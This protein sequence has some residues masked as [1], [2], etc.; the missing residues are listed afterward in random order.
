MATKLQLITELSERTARTITKNPV[1]WTSFLKTASW[2]YKYPFQDQ[3]LIYAQRPDATACAPIELWNRKLDRWVNRGAKGIALIDDSGSRLSLRHVFDVSDTNSRYDRPI[4]L[5]AMQDRY[6]E[7]VTETLENAFGEPEE[8]QDMASALISAARNAVED[9]FPDYLTDLVDCRTNSF[10]EELDNLNVEVIFKEVLKNSIAYMLLVRCGYNADEYLSLD[11]LQGVFNFN[12]LDTVSRLGAATSDISEMVLREIGATVKEMQ[13]TE[14]KKSHTFAKNQE[15]RHNKNVKQN[16]DSERNGEYGTDLHAQGRLSDSRPDVAGGRN[17]H[18]QIWDVAQNISEKP[19]ERDVRQP[20]A[21]GQANGTPHGDRPDGEGTRRENHGEALG[22]QSRTGQGSR[23]D[24]LDGTHEQ[25]E[26]SSGGNGAGG[27]DL[28][29]NLFPTFE[30][31]IEVIE[32]AEEETSSAFSIPQEV[33]DSVLRQGSGVQNGKYRIYLHF[34]QNASAKENADFL[35]NEYGIGGHGPA[36]IDSKIDEWHD[37]KGITLTRGKPI[38]PDSKVV[39][40]WAKVQKRIGELIAADRYL[41]IKEKECL[42]VYERQTEERGQQFA[43]EDYAREILN[44]EP[45]PSE[46]KPPLGED[47]RYNFSLGDTV[48]LGTDEY[49]IFSYDDSFVQ[50]RDINFPLLGKELSRSDFDRMLQEN[51]LNDHLISDEQETLATQAEAP[52][53]Q[54]AEKE[55]APSPRELYQTYLPQIINR[56]RTDE[57]YPY[58]WDKDTDPDSAERE[59]DNA[60]HRIMLSMREEHSAFYQAYTSLPKFKEWLHEDVFQWIYQDYLTEKRDSAT[61]HADDPDAPEWVRATGDV[62]ITPEGDTVTIDSEDKGEKSYVEFDLEPPDSQ[63]EETEKQPVEITEKQGI[64]KQPRVNFHI[65]DDDLG[66]GGAK[67]KYG[68]NVDAI[69]LLNQLEEQNRLATPEEQEILS[70]YVGWG[71]LPQV[72]DEQNSQWA[73]EYTELKEL[74]TDEEY[75]SARASTLN[76]HYTSPIVIKA[77]YDCLANMGFETGNILE[78][79]CGTGNFFGLVPESMKNSK[80]YGVELDG[81]TGRIAKQLYQ[82]ASIAVQGFEETNLPDS[83]FDLAVGNVPFGSYGVADKKYDKYKFYIH[84]YFFAKTLDKVR[85]GGII[86]FITSKGTLDKQNPEV[87]KYIAQRAELLGAVRLPNNAFLANAGTEVTTDI[88]F[89]QKRDRV[90]DI[91]PD[92]VHLSTIGDGISINQYF[93]DNP[94]M[95]LGTMAYDERMYG[96][97]NETTCVPHEDTDLSELLREALENIHAEITEY[98]LDEL[99][100]D[101]D[102]SIPADSDVRNFSFCLMDGE[103]YYRENSRMNRVETSVTAQ[104]R[105]KGMIAIRD[106]VRELIEYQTEDYSDEIIREQQQKLN[107]LYDA[108]TAKYGLLNSRG[109]NMAFSDDS[110]YCLLC[111]LEILD[112]DGNLERKADMFTKRTIRQRTSVTHVDTATEALAISIGEKACVDIGFMQT[113]TGLSE[114]QILKELEGV[115]FRNPEKTDNEGNPR[116]ETEDEYLSGNVR[117]KLKTARQF[118]EMYPDLYGV[119]VKALEAVQPKDL[120]ASQIDVRLGATWLPPDVIKDFMLELLETPYMY[121]RYIGVL[122]SAYTA[123]WNVKGKNDDR[124]DNIKANVTYGTKRINAYKIIEETLNLKDVRIFDTIIEDGNEKRVLNKKETAIAQQKQEAIKEAFQSWIWKDPQRRERLTRIYNDR[125]NSIRPREYDGSHIRFTGMNPEITLRKHQVD[126][127]AH[128][129]YGGNTLLAHCVGAGKTYEMAAI[130]MESKHLGLCQKSLFVVPNHLTEQWAAE[131]LQ[132]YPSANILVST[133]K[134][135]ETKN[136]KKFCARIATGD[137]DAVI[138]GHSQFEKIPISQE[139]QKRQLEEQISEI[140]GGIRELKEEHGE[141][142]AIKQLEKT[143]KTLKLRLDKLNDTSRKDDVVTFEEL[144]VDRLF[145]DEADFY[146]N[147]FLYTKMRN[148]AGLSQTNA[149][150]SSDLFAKC[151]YLDERTEGRGTIFATGTPISN[152]ITEMYTMQRYLQYEVL[153]RNGLQ[154]FDCWASTFGETVTAIE[155]A[156]EGTG[157]RAKTRF[158][159]FYNLPELMNMFKEVADIKTADML[160]LPVP[161]ANYHNVAV[162]PSEFQQNMVAELAERA[163]RVRN[164]MVEPYEDNMLKITNDGRKLALDQR[165][166]NPMLPDHDRSKVNACVDNTFQL[167][168]ENRDQRLTQLVFCDLSTP[169]NDGNFNIY[170]DVRQKLIDRGVPADEIAFIHDANTE[171]RKKE[172]FA[173]VRKGQVRILLGSTFKMGAGTNVQDRLIALHDLDCPWRPRDLEQ[174]SG[175]IVRQGNKNDEVHIFRYVTENTFDAYLYQILE[176]KQRFISQIMTGKSPVRSAE[177]IDETALSYAEVKALATGNPYI[178]EKMDI[179]IQ[180]SKLKLLKANHLSQRYALED[181]LLKHYPQQIKSTEERITGYE[182]D[183]A[184]F[185]RYSTPELVRDSAE[186]SKFAGMTVKD[187]RYTEKAKA[188]KA[189]LEA[190]KLMTSPEPQELGNYMGFPMLFSFDSFNKQYQITLRGALSHTVTLGT[191]IHGNITRLNNVLAE[192]PKKLEYCQE[193]LK[194]LR[195]QMETAKKEIDIPFEK[196]QELQTKSARLAELNI[197]LN[198]D[199]QENE[200]MD[201]EPDEDMDVPERKAVGYER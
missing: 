147:L 142:Y 23:P 119:N 157:Y 27:A 53:E 50:L 65:T 104:G 81:I 96:N 17:A 167:W 115:V 5:W 89:L 10:L 38:E 36:L 106:C 110:S 123:N 101:E 131:F 11:E 133:K 154:H 85:P 45:A 180:V 182:K 152:S 79:A 28:Q 137:Y 176:N 169:K 201:G 42:P 74:L 126:A 68:R 4:V 173:K 145:V 34:R 138:I 189:I 29:L 87:R 37:G 197:L 111:S 150:K 69:R 166:A 52:A 129:L 49:E 48:Y 25:P 155:L 190:C 1:N 14:K 122:Y 120:D 116:Y 148:V 191:D 146:K 80:L 16:I 199:K 91:E 46:P 44:R 100:D 43:E 140:T 144:G 143:K 198:M 95:V 128:G 127:V 177:D 160:N 40:S 86:A 32:K 75:T 60:I 83:F 159:R 51:P 178:K 187:I 195:Q 71:G 141:R 161:K 18:R 174:R 13:I 188:G 117:E 164:R 9:N 57:I 72:F 55:Q 113:L 151:R 3:V 54:P 64:P 30:Q 92:W 47:T 132:L 35:K 84:D 24:W 107:N 156:P 193:Q 158:A 19:Q 181:R 70:R 73:K 59:L 8:K 21:V 7:A 109:N 118:A 179:D 15:V 108:F 124:S 22:E 165:L 62:I 136:R 82:N 31:Q 200:I 102:T 76:A 192:I 12:T 2:N 77:M 98:E 170:G 41:N 125:F 163:E 20:D 33:I 130:A 67:T 88:I 139:R 56:I 185:E 183:L 168:Q 135:F 175:R 97:Q 103:I 112:E 162:K 94:D 26:T 153:R 66:V 172:L 184:M 61:L 78:P 114:E 39:L 63:A 90:I 149:Q 6:A 105:I 194:T 171:T 93:A 196:E 134:D 99:S 186:D 121:R 58:L